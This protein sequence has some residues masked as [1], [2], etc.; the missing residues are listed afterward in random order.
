MGTH[1]LGVSPQRINLFRRRALAR[2]AL[3]QLGQIPNF[4]VRCGR[5]I[6]HVHRSVLQD[7]GPFQRLML[8]SPRPLMNVST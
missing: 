2:H 6:F 8:L 1:P 3:Q 7:D 5:A 4:L